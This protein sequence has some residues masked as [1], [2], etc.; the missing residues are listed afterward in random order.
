MLNFAREHTIVAAHIVGIGGVTQVELGFYSLEEMEY[1]FKSFS[2]T[3]EITSLLGN[4]TLKNDEPFLHAHITVANKEYQ[5]LGGHLK[6]AIVGGTCE[7]NMVVHTAP[8]YRSIDQETGLA[9]WDFE[10]IREV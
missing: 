7:I 3:L 1:T 8:L 10:P 4:I 9:L 5:V 2:E 6:E